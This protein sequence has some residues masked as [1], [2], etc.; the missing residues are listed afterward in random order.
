MIQQQTFCKD[1]SGDSAEPRLFCVANGPTGNS[2]GIVLKKL[3]LWMLFVSFPF[4]QLVSPTLAA[5]QGV[6]AVTTKLLKGPSGTHYTLLFQN[7]CK[8]RWTTQRPKSE[9]H[10]KLCIP[11]AFTASDGGVVGLYALKGKF[12]NQ[13][14]RDL[15]IG[16][17]VAT[18]DGKCRIVG[19]SQ[20]DIDIKLL[21]E[22]L[23][24][25]GDLFQQFQVVANGSGEK[26]RDSTRFQRRGIATFKDGACAVIESFESITLSQFGADL[27][28]MGVDQFAYTD[29]GPWD[30]GWYRD[31]KSGRVIIIG[32]DRAY[33]SRQS[34]W[35]VFEQLITATALGAPHSSRHRGPLRASNAQAA[36]PT[37]RAAKQQ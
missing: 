23:Q 2:R 5:S 18:I 17:V 14:N 26:F 36:P 31:S 29:M 15:S 35:L 24:K 8:A 12:Y 25:K 33:T 21:K 19:A 3:K 7:D 1:C 11:A 28:N 13:N 20:G 10:I 9:E 4:L 32:R 27:A 22:V 34:N 37:D 16:G 30:E 6:A